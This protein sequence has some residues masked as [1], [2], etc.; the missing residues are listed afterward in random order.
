MWCLRAPSSAMAGREAGRTGREGVYMGWG[1]P[2]H[3]RCSTKYSL[4]QRARHAPCD[5]SLQQSTARHGSTHVCTGSLARCILR[6]RLGI[7]GTRVHGRGHAVPC[8]QG[9]RYPRAGTLQVRA[10]NRQLRCAALNCASLSGNAALRC[11]G[12]ARLCDVLI[13]ARRD[14][15]G[16]RSGHRVAAD[17]RAA[18]RLN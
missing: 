8:D 5:G 1:H 18:V 15:R 7:H 2:T 9:T 14:A 11:A 17:A 3:R 16:R 10:A 13:G 4:Q 12:P 6:R